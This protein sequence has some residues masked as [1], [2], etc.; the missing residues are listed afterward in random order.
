MW[1]KLNTYGGFARSNE[2]YQKKTCSQDSPN[3][4]DI[5]KPVHLSSM[6]VINITSME[7]KTMVPKSLMDSESFD[8]TG[9]IEQVF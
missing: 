1:H 2:P 3:F 9:C 6:I 4:G 8:Q 7:R 5:D